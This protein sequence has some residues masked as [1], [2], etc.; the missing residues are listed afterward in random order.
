[1]IKKTRVE[2]R[3]R[4]KRHIRLRVKGTAERP[5]LTVYRSLRHV[6]VQIVDDVAGKTLVSVSDLS[7]GAQDRFKEAKGQVAVGKLVGQLAAARA[8]EKNITQVV[9]DRNGYLYHGAVKALADAAR[10]GGLTL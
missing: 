8:K 10:E 3:R 6:Y 5:R 7:K 9:F 4:I 1:M 2:H